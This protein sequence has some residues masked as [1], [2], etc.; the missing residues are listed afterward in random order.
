MPRRAPSPPPGDGA[1]PVFLECLT[2]RF[3]AHHTWEH[4]A[5]VN[6]RDAGEVADG[7][8]RDPLDVQAARLSEV[9]RAALDEEV[10]SVIDAAV[11][12]A[13]NGPRPDPSG[14][15]DYLYRS[16][17]RGRSGTGEPHLTPSTRTVT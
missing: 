13:L 10:E 7:R 16:G 2:Y 9:E 5:R 12:F 14:A 8:A 17:L 11:A 1:G 3:D 4:K 6:Y 15:L